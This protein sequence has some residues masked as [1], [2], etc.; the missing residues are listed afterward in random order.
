VRIARQLRIAFVRVDVLFLAA[1]E[2]LDRF[3][4]V[5]VVYV[6]IAC[7]NLA[8]KPRCPHDTLFGVYM[9]RIFFQTANEGFLP[10][11]AVG[12]MFVN[13]SRL[14]SADRNRIRVKTTFAV[15]M[16]FA[17][18]ET[19]DIFI[20]FRAVY[21][22][23]IFV[24]SAYRHP[25]F[26]VAILRVLVFRIVFQTAQENG[27]GRPALFAVNMTFALF[28]TADIPGIREETILGVNMS[29]VLL[30]GTYEPRLRGVTLFRVGMFFKTARRS[31]FR[32]SRRHNQRRNGRNCYRR[33][34]PREGDFS[35]SSLYRGLNGFV[36][37]V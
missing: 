27:F 24:Q 5:L 10:F 36:T 8:D 22:F 13:R 11:D 31:V 17:L 12:G 15:G 7:G 34:E 16:P 18:F 2:N 32:R 28:K 3:I 21:V 30:K 37:Q 33:R 35:L 25:P 14:Q 9:L 19:A 26:A 29:F 6:A 1:D 4:A 20:A 23:R